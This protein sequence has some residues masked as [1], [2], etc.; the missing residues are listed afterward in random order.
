M[1]QPNIQCFIANGVKGIFEQGSYQSPG[2][3]LRELRSWPLAKPLWNPRANVNALMN[4]FLAGYHGPAA[5]FIRRYMDLMHDEVTRTKHELKYYPPTTAPFLSQPVIAKADALFASAEKTVAKDAALLHRVKAARLPVH[6]V[7][8]QRE[9]AWKRSGAK[10][11]P[12][13]SGHALR[14]RFF[15][16]AA[17]EKMTTINEGRSMD[18]FRT[19]TRLPDRRAPLPPSRKLRIGCVGIGGQGDGVTAELATFENV[20]IAALCDVDD[21]Y[22][23]RNIKKYPGRPL[24]KDYRVMLDKEK[25]LDAVMV[26]TPDHWHA[27]ISIA[28]MQLGKHVYCEKPLAHSVEEARLMARVARET[29]VVTQMGNQ[30]HAGEGLRLTKEWIDAGAIGRISEVHVWSDRPGKFWQTQGRLR[31]TDTPP[32]PAGLDWNL[33]LGPAKERPYHPD[34][35]PRQWRGWIDFGCG[36]LGDIGAGMAGWLRGQGGLTSAA[37]RSAT[38]RCTMPTR[39]STRST[40]ARRTGPRRSPRRRI[41]IHSRSGASSPAI[42]PPRAT[43]AR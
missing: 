4:A 42:S 34:Y 22:A 36:A 6:Y 2:G 10:W 5:P 9:K 37:A 23:A 12:S 18:D 30:G 27:P 19:A 13:L 26:G 14:E 32:V 17:A 41:P 11:Q 28:A 21:K 38:W 35:C 24:Y 1:L 40:S 16:I 20:E 15:E 3:E 31:P 29:G 25:G 43:A 8:M 39:R 7:M 33:W